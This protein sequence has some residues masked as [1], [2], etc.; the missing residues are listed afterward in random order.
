M[1]EHPDYQAHLKR[2]VVKEFET[3]LSI[4]KSRIDLGQSLAFQ[5]SSRAFIEGTSRKGFKDPR[6]HGK[7]S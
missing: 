1:I 2:G 4:A 3:L 5:R 6:P 7:G